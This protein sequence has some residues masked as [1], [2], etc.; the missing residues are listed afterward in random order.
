LFRLDLIPLFSS[1]FFSWCWG[2]FTS[3]WRFYLEGVW[4]W[5][6]SGSSDG[7]SRQKWD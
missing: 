7:T 4:L 6:I 2:G 1:L 3:V 5:R